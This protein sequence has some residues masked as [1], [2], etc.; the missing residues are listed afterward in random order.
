MKVTTS[1]L[2]Q[3]VLEG[4]RAEGEPV[5]FVHGNVSSAAFWRDTL[6]AM[7]DDYRPLAADLRGF[8]ESDP[9]PVDATRGLR[10]FSDDL[11]ELVAAMEL[12]PVHLVGWSMGGG[13]VMQVL[14]DHPALVRSLTLVNPVSPYGYSGTEGADGVL[15][16][17]DGTG[18]GAGAANTDFVARLAK[19]DTS[20]ESPTSPRSVF[21]TSYVAKPVADEDF[22]VASMLT[23]R[24]GDD[25]YPGD[26]VTS[27]AWPGVRPGTRGVLNALAPTHFRIDDLHTVEPRPPILW[28]RGADDVIVSDASPFDLAQL[29]LLGIVPGSPG[30]PAQPMVTQT[31]AALERY[32]DYREAVLAECGHSPHLEHPEEFRRLLVAHLQARR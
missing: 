19:G 1:R 30:T 8:G 31:R 27:A 32:G 20:A 10:D 4:P 17:A 6:A 22:Y 28:I 15:T 7:P 18:A 21:R 25:N 3:N 13:V 14:R 9:A 26:A 5:L 12:G 16:H 2:T 23:T 29:G 24:V 11:V